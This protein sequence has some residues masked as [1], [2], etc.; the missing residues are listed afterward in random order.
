ML[1]LV[2]PIKTHMSKPISATVP[3]LV[4]S[5]L[6]EWAREEGRS[7]SNLIAA[8]L[9]KVCVVR[10]PDRFDTYWQD[11]ETNAVDYLKA[12]IAQED[13]IAYAQLEAIALLLAMDTATLL[14]R[15]VNEGLTISK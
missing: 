8:I 7:R 6:D 12:F 13:T 3:D 2:N 4:D 5:C 11:T 15:C 10:F 14:Q 9:E 1:S